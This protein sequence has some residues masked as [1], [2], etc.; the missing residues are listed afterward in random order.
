M[1]A[2]VVD[3]EHIAYLVEAAR[4]YEIV[5]YGPEDIQRLSKRE[6]KDRLSHIGQMLWDENIRSVQARYPEDTIHTMP[7][8]LDDIPFEYGH[9]FTFRDGQITPLQVLA[10]CG[11]Y[12]YQACES[13]DWPETEAYRFIR[14]LEKNA[15]VR[16][17]G[18]SDAPNFPTPD[19][20]LRA[21]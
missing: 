11:R 4:L 7:C 9:T 12:E 2:F 19:Q 14:A 3:K 20:Q 13:D 5:W 18:Y 6:D 1:S 15:I 17:P 16:L 8:K 10:S 21:V